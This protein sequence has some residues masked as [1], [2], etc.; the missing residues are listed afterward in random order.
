MRRPCDGS[1]PSCSRVIF[2]ISA[3]FGV[4]VT[5]YSSSGS[6]LKLWGVVCSIFSMWIAPCS[7]S[8]KHFSRDR[9][10]PGLSIGR[11][12]APG[13]DRPVLRAVLFDFNGVLVDDEPIHLETL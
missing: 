6:S 13:Y 11:R 12:A 9:P 7:D 1:M 4:S 8:P 2:T 5:G 3:A 10:T